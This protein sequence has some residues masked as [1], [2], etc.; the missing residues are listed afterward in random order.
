MGTDAVSSSVQLVVGIVYMVSELTPSTILVTLPAASYCISRLTRS[1]ESLESLILLRAAK[2]EREA[3]SI[4]QYSKDW[5]AG[6]G[7]AAESV[8]IRQADF[9]VY[10]VR[11]DIEAVDRRLNPIE[12]QV[13]LVGVGQGL[14]VG[15]G[16]LADPIQRIE[17]V[18]GCIGPAVYDAGR[19]GRPAVLIVGPGRISGGSPT[20]PCAGP[21][22]SRRRFR[23]VARAGQLSGL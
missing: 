19:S 2:G 22:R 20:S 10:D 21:C 1:V 14:A 11:D 15:I 23:L 5:V 9:L 12:Q 6:C 3:S 13:G 18:V 16:H 7:T 17:G 8:A 4:F